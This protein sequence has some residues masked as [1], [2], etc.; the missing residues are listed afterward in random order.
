[1]KLVKSPLRLLTVGALGV[2]LTLPMMSDAFARDRYHHRGGHHR[3]GGSNTGAYVA[4][5]LGAAA[6][7]GLLAYEAT[8]P[9]VVYQAP[10]TYY[11]PPPAYYSQPAPTYYVPPATTYYY[12]SSP[13]TYTYSDAPYE[14]LRHWGN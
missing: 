1:M 4:L 14:Q 3:G 5:G 10:P 13:P 9:R 8:R 12:E 2:A 6:I 11:A 7:G